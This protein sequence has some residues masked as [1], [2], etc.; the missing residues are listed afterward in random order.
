MTEGVDYCGPKGFLSIYIG[1][2][3]EIL[4]KRLYLVIKS[5]PIVPGGRTLMAI[6]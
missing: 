6:G 2:V 5:T 1:K 4:D 3:D